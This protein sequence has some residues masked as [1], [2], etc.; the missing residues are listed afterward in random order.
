MMIRWK[1]WGRVGLLAN[2]V[3]ILLSG[4]VSQPAHGQ[5]AATLKEAAASR[6][7]LIGSSTFDINYQR[8]IYPAIPDPGPAYYETLRREFNYVTVESEM[9]WDATEPTYTEPDATFN[10]GPAEAI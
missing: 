4:A 8:L 1:R 2:F 3:I 7:M 6:D 10:F 5:T 9:K